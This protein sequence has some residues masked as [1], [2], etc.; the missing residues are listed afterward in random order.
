[1]K[2]LTFK[3][4][5]AGLIIDGYK[6]VENRSR[7]TSW[8]KRICVHAGKSWW[9][10]PEADNMPDSPHQHYAGF[11]IGTVDVVG[12]VCGYRS[13]WAE[14]GYWHWIL[15]N[16]LPLRSPI[17]MPG[18]Q[19]WFEVPDECLPLRHLSELSPRRHR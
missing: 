8:P 10:G 2:A 16:P 11:V 15:R 3:Q 12:C 19:Y 4:P 6:N 7:P 1:M 17:E 9:T 13:R 5:W 18:H 14:P